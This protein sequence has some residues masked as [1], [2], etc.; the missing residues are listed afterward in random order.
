MLSSSRLTLLR[1]HNSFWGLL[2]YLRPYL[3][4]LSCLPSP[5]ISS[6]DM[7]MHSQSSEYVVCP[8]DPIYH[9]A[10]SSPSPT[11]Q[12][13]SHTPRSVG[14]LSQ[15]GQVCANNLF[16]PNPPLSSSPSSSSGSMSS[17]G[18]SPHSSPAGRL[19]GDD[20]PYPYVSLVEPPQYVFTP[21][22]RAAPSPN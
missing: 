21:Y 18:N 6:S 13:A 11:H 8:N 7:E 17:R 22:I 9:S 3:F 5:T 19:V 12:I 20:Y 16:V 15:M 14:L 1:C 4:R 10:H 2:I